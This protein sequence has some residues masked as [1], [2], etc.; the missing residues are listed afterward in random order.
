MIVWSWDLE[1]M[2][3]LLALEL[4]DFAIYLDKGFWLI[5]A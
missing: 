2:K 3:I 5:D 4:F 1:I